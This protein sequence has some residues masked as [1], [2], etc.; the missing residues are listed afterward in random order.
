MDDEGPR[1]SVD[2][3]VFAFDASSRVTIGRSSSKSE[4][5]IRHPR[6]SGAH[7]AVTPGRDGSSWLV[8]LSS[9][10]GTFLDS[11]CL[12]PGEA[13]QAQ[14]HVGVT[15]ALGPVAMRFLDQAHLL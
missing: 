1:D 11:R 6:V 3:V 14:L 10:N 2:F 12:A 7:A 9:S 8:D 4:I 5:V 13:A 15:L